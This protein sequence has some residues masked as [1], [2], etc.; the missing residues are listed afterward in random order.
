ML[1]KTDGL[2]L[3]E[4]R[5]LGLVLARRLVFLVG[6]RHLLLQLFRA[7]EATV[8]EALLVQLVT[9]DHVYTLL[10][11]LDPLESVLEEVLLLRLH[12]AVQVM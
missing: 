8:N 4:D 2:W 5:V 10:I 7:V 11:L 3:P 9:H 6:H 12:F 1:R